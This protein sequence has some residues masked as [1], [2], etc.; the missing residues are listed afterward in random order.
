MLVFVSQRAA[1]RS[2][3]D[4]AVLAAPDNSGLVRYQL[5]VSRQRFDLRDLAVLRLR[6][7]CLS[8][9]CRQRPEAYLF[10]DLVQRT[11]LRH[12]NVTAVAV[13]DGLSLIGRAAV[14]ALSRETLDRRSPR[15]VIDG[16]RYGRR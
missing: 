10:L 4:L 8:H 14:L 12:F 6:L 16:R 13:H 15:F 3:L 5:A 9:I 11:V 1:V 2:N 7:K